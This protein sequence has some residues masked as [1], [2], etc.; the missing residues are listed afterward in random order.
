MKRK[1][2][3]ILVYLLILFG[4]AGCGNSEQKKDENNKTTS[5]TTSTTTT[6]TS[7]TTT[8]A[9]SFKLSK[10]E[11]V[12]KKSAYKGGYL[13]KIRLSSKNIIESSSC[14]E[15]G[16][17]GSESGTY[18]IS[19]NKISYKMTKKWDIGWEIDGETIKNPKT[20]NCEIIKDNIFK[21]NNITYTLNK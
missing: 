15:N 5:S 7:S 18:K 11:Y 6:T 21:C 17:C 20:I 10:G 13:A 3:L 8:P 16:G 1:Y 9:Q 12:N 4:V 2:V 14:A 19:N